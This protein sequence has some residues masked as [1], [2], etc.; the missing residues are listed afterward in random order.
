MRESTAQ[1]ANSLS[2]GD[3]PHQSCP[4]VEALGNVK[5][6]VSRRFAR[7][8]KVAQHVYKMAARVVVRHEGVD[9]IDNNS[10]VIR[11]V[12]PCANHPSLVSKVLMKA[13]SVLH[14]D[15]EVSLRK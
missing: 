3:K 1:H 2:E 4:T 5:Q 8:I 7:G 14:R 13:S 9:N 11:F 12:Q 15:Q 10:S 6:C